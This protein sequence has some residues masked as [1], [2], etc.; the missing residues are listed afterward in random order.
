MAGAGVP[1]GARLVVA[2]VAAASNGSS[3]PPSES[4]RVLGTLSMSYEVERMIGSAVSLV[5]STGVSMRGGTGEP[6]AL[7]TGL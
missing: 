4:R 2:V 1:S 3:M 6:L 5:I 7:I